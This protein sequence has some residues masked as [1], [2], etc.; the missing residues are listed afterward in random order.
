[1]KT[2]PLLS[3]LLLFASFGFPPVFAAD[4]SHEPQSTYVIV[5]GAWGGGWAFKEVDRLLT[6]DGNH[7]YRPTL[8]GLGEKS[9]LARPDI[10]LTTHITDIVNVILW[11]DLHD[12]VLVGHSYGGMV[13]TGVID[14]VPDRIKRVVYLDALVPETGESWQTL[15]PTPP[16]DVK[17]VNGFY[18]PPWVNDFSAKPP[19]DMP[20]PAATYTEPLILTHS[21][22]PKIPTT[23]IL[24]VDEGKQ[25][26]D[27]GFFPSYQRAKKYGWE[28]VVMTGDHNVQ[29]SKPKELV[30]LLETKTG[31]TSR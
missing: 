10:N 26:E 23:Y 6:A 8:T 5:H 15:R 1:M 3:L 30:T 7:V 19:H 27:D 31:Q 9:H 20:H 21:P 12:I 11:E 25:P 14:R 29:W 4:V 24:T 18:V 13:I 16:G 28:T 17:L 22:P 2:H